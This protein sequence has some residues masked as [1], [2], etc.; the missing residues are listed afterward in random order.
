[1]QFVR[2]IL[3][4]LL[5]IVEGALLLR[6]RLNHLFNA[7]HWQV[8]EAARLLTAHDRHVASRV[9]ALGRTVHRIELPPLF[10]V[11][12]KGQIQ[13]DGAEGR[14]IAAAASERRAV[15][16]AEASTVQR[17]PLKTAKTSLA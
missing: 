9:I 14:V 11:Q 13:Y 4:C 10:I 6:S 12:R 3:R 17:P 8:D 2:R 1:L 15:R 16:T 5:E 7:L